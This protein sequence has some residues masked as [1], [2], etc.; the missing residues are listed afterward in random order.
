MSIIFIIRNKLKLYIFLI[1]ICKMKDGI[2]ERRSFEIVLEG[3]CLGSGSRE[4]VIERG[5]FIV[6][7]VY[8]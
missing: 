3:N 8:Y 7:V 1:F 4:V 5:I 2:L 6:F